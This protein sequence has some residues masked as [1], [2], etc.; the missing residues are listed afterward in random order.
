[1]TQAQLGEAMGLSRG[2]IAKIEIGI[3]R[4]LTHSLVQFAT[5]LGV[6]AED[7]LPAQQ[8]S[9]ADEKSS[10]SEAMEAELGKVNELIAAAS[11]KLKRI[12]RK[13]APAK[14]A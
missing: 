10:E 13:K 1:M 12:N 5:V 6:K 14:A 8:Q 7:L 9:D 4:H 2:S 11:V 3:Q